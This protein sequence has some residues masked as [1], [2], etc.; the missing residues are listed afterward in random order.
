MKNG[1][2]KKA[3]AI[4]YNEGDIA[5]KVIAKGKGEVAKKIINKGKEE[6][7]EVVENKEI[8]DKLINLDIGQ[9]IPEELYTAVAEIL[10]FV[11]QLDKNKGDN[12]GE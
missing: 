2:K 4:K 10:A 7:I 11:Y 8:T 12:L 9:E 6:G 5:P 1:N 3:V